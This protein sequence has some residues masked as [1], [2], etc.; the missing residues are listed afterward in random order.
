MARIVMIAA[1]VACAGC[2]GALRPA[3]SSQRPNEDALLVLTGLGYG[4]DGQRAW[5]SLAAEMAARGID[6]YVPD[7]LT[8][9][10]LASSRENLDEFIREARLDRY[11]RVH[12]FAFIAGAWTVNPLVDAARLPNLASVIYDRSPYQE[13]AAAVVVSQHPVFAWLRYGKTVFEIARTPYAPITRPGVNVAL[14]VESK[15]S[16]F[17]RRHEKAAQERG[18]LAFD[19]GAFLQRYD[20]C[21]Y[22]PLS[23]GELYA[24]MR[25]VWPEILSFVRT[26]RFTSN[27]T[28]TP[29]IGDPLGR[30]RS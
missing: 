30:P 25:D 20:D 13:R 18:P 16:P 9:S 19:C 4:R 6:L 8:R 2:A 7:Y 12:I 17:M 14:L 27:I 24:R 15:P 21:A 11:A 26:S 1:F 22:V 28:R 29:P 10:G 5:Q 3:T 23:H